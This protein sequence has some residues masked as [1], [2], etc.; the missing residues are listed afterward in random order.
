AGD[1]PPPTARGEKGQF[2]FTFKHRFAAGSHLVTVQSEPDALPADDR[3]DFAL[4]VL[5]QLPVLLVD[6]DPNPAATHR[7]SDFLRD[8]LAP[9]RDPHPAVLARVVSIAEFDPAMLTRDLAG[10][11]TVP[12]VVVL[13]NVARLT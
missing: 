6:G 13:C 9:A 4:E 7:G 10:P 3:Q 2:P 5:P 11:G 8:A 1:L 12:R